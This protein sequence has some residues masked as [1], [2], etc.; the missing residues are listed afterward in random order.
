M[1]KLIAFVVLCIFLSSCSNYSTETASNNQTIENYTI[2]L[3]I[4]EDNIL[5]KQMADILIQKLDEK[6]NGAL[7]ISMV[8]EQEEADIYIN[9]VSE[10]LNYDLKYY[11]LI[12]PFIFRN[13]DHADIS[14]NSVL[15]ESNLMYQTQ[16]EN[17]IVYLSGFVG[18]ASHIMTNITEYMPIDDLESL[19]IGIYADTYAGYLLE[20]LGASVYYASSQQELEEQFTTGEINAIG[21]NLNYLSSIAN[22]K[23]QII[24]SYYE[25]EVELLF[26]KD[27]FWEKISEQ[28]KAAIDE[29]IAA[30]L[31]T[32]YQSLTAQ[33]ILL[34]NRITQS[35]EGEN[36]FTQTT[37][38][39]EREILSTYARWGIITRMLDEE[40]FFDI[41]Q[42]S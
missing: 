4:D 10:L 34:L 35:E 16:E 18:S 29:A 32:W 5:Q 14:L 24:P 1:T 22:T 37:E 12:M 19:N 40:L 39:I 26:A 38:N 15:P 7:Q 27:V 8:S 25:M 23:Y 21:G 30:S 17:S 3:A 33:D 41:A 9:N 11:T 28:Q 13:Y 42:L 31:Y 36:L 20:N 2:K 6:T